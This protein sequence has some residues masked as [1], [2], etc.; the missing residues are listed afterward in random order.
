MLGRRRY[1]IKDKVNNP[2]IAVEKA[3][4]VTNIQEYVVHDGPGLRVIVFFRGCPLNCSWCQNPECLDPLPQIQYRASL[5]LN[6]QKCSEVCPI[7]G[8]IVDDKERRIDRSKCTRCMACVDTCLGRALR[9]VGEWMTVDQIMQSILR[10]KPFFDHS[11]N[12]GVTLSG[13]DPVFQPEF[14]LALLKSCRE[15][16]IHTTV[17]TCGHT[18]YETLK[19]IVD[20]SDLII[21]D[22]KHM[23]EAYHILGTGASNRLI[24]DNLKKLCQEVDTKIVVH[25]PL[26][27]GFNDS[28]DNI[29][30]TAEFVSSLKKIRR[31]DLLPF[32]E[33]ASGKYLTMGIDW[34]CANMRRQPPEQLAKLRQIVESYGL[35]VTIGGLW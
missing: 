3:G 9:K 35:K 1:P 5:C 27:P 30:K 13:G 23:D 19:R 6:C 24:L 32:N 7:P 11:E 4:W 16:G 34:S 33:L 28:E 10:Y 8:A 21:Y 25:I 20:A 29:T 14:T 12:G 31:L 18:N 2:D 22:L 15:M 26:I 17:E